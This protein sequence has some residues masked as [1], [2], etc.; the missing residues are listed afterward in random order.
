[1]HKVEPE[2]RVDGHTVVIE[3]PI[4]L[5]SEDR[6]FGLIQFG[7]MIV[8]LVF[9]LPDFRMFRF[10]L[11]AALVIRSGFAIM[12][13]AIGVFVSSRAF[14][15]PPKPV[16]IT[17][18]PDFLIYDS[19]RAGLHYLGNNFENNLSRFY[20]TALQRR[21]TWE[22]ARSETQDAQCKVVTNGLR[23]IVRC[24]DRTYDLGIGIPESLQYAVRDAIRAWM[25]A[26]PSDAPAIASHA[27][28]NG[29]STE[30][31]S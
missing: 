3:I 31:A 12:W 29:R 15:F 2:T 4:G 9:L 1:M 22:L 23:T 13:T 5:P 25:S 21:K 17:F 16:L 18:G 10:G 11:D 26:A 8:A 30:N 24:G 28:S 19:G 7:V 14:L 6:D 27:F 20:R